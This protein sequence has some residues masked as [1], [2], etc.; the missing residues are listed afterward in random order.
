MEMDQRT[1]GSPWPASQVGSASERASGGRPAGASPEPLAIGEPS[2]NSGVAPP[3]QATESCR[4]TSSKLS[5]DDLSTGASVVSGAQA[6]LGG[7]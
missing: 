2:A 1:L 5:V 6:G 3:C 7:C 4:G